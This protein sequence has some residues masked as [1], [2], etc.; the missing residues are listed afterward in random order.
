MLQR[1]CCNCATIMYV[2]SDFC[3]EKCSDEFDAYMKSEMGCSDTQ[4]Q[5]ESNED[6]S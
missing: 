1:K 6:A 2:Q 5:A 4:E 3:S